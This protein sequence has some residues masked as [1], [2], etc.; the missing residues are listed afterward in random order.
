MAE[1]IKERRTV[2]KQ[3]RLELFVTGESQSEFI[4]RETSIHDSFCEP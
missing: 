4:G 1:A 3:G 2:D